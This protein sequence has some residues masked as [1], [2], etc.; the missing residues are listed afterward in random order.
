MKSIENIVFFSKTNQIF[1]EERQKYNKIQKFLFMTQKFEFISIEN[2]KKLHI[3]FS[4]DILTIQC[5]FCLC[6]NN[7]HNIKL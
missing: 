7:N 3:F 2:L 5:M 6:F 1:L 4:Y